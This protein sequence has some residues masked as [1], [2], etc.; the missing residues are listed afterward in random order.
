MLQVTCA[1]IRDQQKRVLVTQRSA[2]MRLP[3]KW[4]FPGGKIE[5]GETSAACLI[6]E[7]KEE[8]LVDVQLQE[9]LPSNVHHY[10]TFSL[11]LIPFIAIIISGTI[12][13]KE[14]TQYIWADR[15][16]LITL[17]WAAADIPILDH[18]LAH[19]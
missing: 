1:I 15:S 10:E 19:Y 7:I 18:Y 6:R 12:R 14:H 17:D 3:L 11:E 16:Q 4:E 9:R 8:L 5:P 13:L 2:S